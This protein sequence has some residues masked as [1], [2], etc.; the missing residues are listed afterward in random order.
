MYVDAHYRNLFRA[1]C[2]ILLKWP[3]HG[4]WILKRLWNTME[5]M[6]KV[7]GGDKEHFSADV[8]DCMAYQRSP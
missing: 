3:Y 7:I 4:G 6:Q 8:V 5:F 1:I 2:E